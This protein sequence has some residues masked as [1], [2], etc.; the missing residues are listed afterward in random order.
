MLV[1]AR[2]MPKDCNGRDFVSPDVPS[3]MDDFSDSHE[4]S[5]VSAIEVA[6]L[7]LSPVTHVQ[8]DARMTSIPNVV[9]D[10]D[11]VEMAAVVL[12]LVLGT[13][14]EAYK[15]DPQMLSTSPNV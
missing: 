1:E 2:R 8:L 14:P 12:N 7:D 4:Y 5:K 15:N 11:T 13:C 10:V 9:P 3:D 6:R